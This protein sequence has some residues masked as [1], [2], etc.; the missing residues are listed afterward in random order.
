MSSILHVTIRYSLA[1]ETHQVRA[2]LHSC[3]D[4]CSRHCFHKSWSYFCFCL[5]TYLIVPMHSFSLTTHT[6]AC[7]VLCSNTCLHICRS[8]C[9]ELSPESRWF[10]AVSCALVSSIFPEL[11]HA[12]LS[13]VSQG[14]QEAGRET[15][16]NRAEK[17][18]CQCRTQP[19]PTKNC[20]T[21]PKHG[22]RHSILLK[23]WVWL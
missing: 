6:I 20:C 18:R 11:N 22:V 9:L 16:R 10:P 3:G 15:L 19:F 4:P 1:R 7:S 23:G 8:Y 13:G 2:L 17:Q 21:N 5:Y 12:C 14:K